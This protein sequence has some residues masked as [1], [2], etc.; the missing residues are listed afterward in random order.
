MSRSGSAT[1]V[2]MI[3]SGWVLWHDVAVYRAAA[4]TRLAGPTYQVTSYDTEAGCQ[5]GQRTAMA[6][7]ETSRAGGM[8]ERVS[9]GIK[10]WDPDR[11]YYTMLRYRCARTGVAVRSFD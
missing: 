11:E 1:M 8:T 10:V 5:V 2:V 7:E 3:L 9:D 4:Q 6:R